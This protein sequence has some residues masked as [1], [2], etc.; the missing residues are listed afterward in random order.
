MSDSDGGGSPGR[1][2]DAV[3][4][5]AVALGLIVGLILV[6]PILASTASAGGT[7][8]VVPVAGTINGQSTAAA[9]AALQ[10]ARQD[11]SIDAVVVVFNSGGGGAASSEELYLQTKRTAA[12]MP[13]VGAVDSSAASGAYH[14][15]VATDYIYAKPASIVGSVGVLAPLPQSVEPNDIIATTGPNKLT[16]ADR[17]EF[18]YTIESVQESFLSAVFDQRGEEIEIDRSEVAQARIFSGIQA[19]EAGLVDDVGDREAAADRAARMAGLD[20]YEVRVLQPNTTVQFVARSNYAAA[21]VPDKEMVSAAE[22]V[23]EGSAPNLL[24]MPESYVA[25]ALDNRSVMHSATLAGERPA[26]PT[27]NT[28]AADGGVTD[29]E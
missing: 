18:L 19:A 4:I 23:G 2:L 5:V 21:D 11:P 24:M 27:G 6:P 12:E 26:R 8:A 17:R 7:V 1:R 25:D 10:Q 29:G 15:A 28:T 9:T 20:S 22:V 14:T 3:Y 16:G 13:V